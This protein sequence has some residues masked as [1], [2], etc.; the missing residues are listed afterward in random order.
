MPKAW[1]VAEGHC[2]WASGGDHPQWVDL[3][4]VGGK[5]IAL[6]YPK[7][8]D[9]LLTP[10]QARYLASKLYRMARRLENQ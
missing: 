8:V 9:P 3:R 2:V 10:D 7:T 1:S 6:H 5:H 4:E